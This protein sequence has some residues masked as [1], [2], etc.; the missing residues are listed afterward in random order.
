MALRRLTRTELDNTFKQLLGDGSRP[1]DQLPADVSG[2]SGFLTGN[3]VSIVDAQALADM[4]GAVV[5]TALAKLDA[6]AGCAPPATPE[7]ACARQLATAF[8][9]RVFRRPL[10][11][12]E[13]SALGALFD[14]VRSQIGLDYKASMGILLQ[15]ILQSPSFLYHWQV[16]P[17]GARREGG[18]VRL[19]PYELASRLSYFLWQ[20][21][22]DDALFDAADRGRLATAADV[23]REA[24]RML[25]DARAK[26]ALLEFHLQWLRLAGVEKLQVGTVLP[27]RAAQAAADEV[28]ALVDHVMAGDGG[29]KL[30]VL[31]SAPLGFANADLAKV[32]GIG[33]VTGTNLRKVDLDP[34]QRAGIFT[35]VGFLALNAKGLASEPIYR[36][37]VLLE[38]VLCE[39]KPPPLPAAPRLAD[40]QPN[41]TTREQHQMHQSNPVCVGCHQSFEPL[42]YAFESYDGAGRWR[43]QDAGKPVDASGTVTTPNGN[44]TFT[45]KN[46]V[47]L[48][49][50][51]AGSKQVHA[52]AAKKLRRY[53]SGLPESDADAANLDAAVAAF[54]RSGLDLRELMVALATG[55]SFLYRAPSAGEALP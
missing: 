48:A 20:S 47:D 9:K 37:V 30:S 18:L 39:Q 21:M 26:P 12:A 44:E 55:P 29:G 24:R 10:D 51:L 45:F 54:E 31:L 38:Q 5:A 6:L 35:S 17:Q 52:C 50:G 27:S 13:V 23:E 46:A 3:D 53:E 41:V 43:T 15:A 22:P 34:A 33:G 4:T 14:K 40:P 2:D 25:A 7:A 42:G 36:G 19:G 8:G 49:R 11:A 32:Y 16:G 1:A 28:A